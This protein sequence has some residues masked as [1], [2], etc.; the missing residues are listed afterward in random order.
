MAVVA[1]IKGPTGAT[2][3]TGP[4]GPTGSTGAAGSVWYSG[5][6]VP[7]AGT[8]VNGDFYLNTANGDVYQKAGGSW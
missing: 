5:S 8:G 3:P 7:S 4:T 1:N 2:G 6:G